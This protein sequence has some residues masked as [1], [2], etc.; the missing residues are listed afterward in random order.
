VA[1]LQPIA[2]RQRSTFVAQH[3]EHSGDR[4]PRDGRRD[5][6]TQPA[7]ERLRRQDVRPSVTQCCSSDKVIA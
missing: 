6:P 4:Q 7:A 2:N 3:L 1:Y 5:P